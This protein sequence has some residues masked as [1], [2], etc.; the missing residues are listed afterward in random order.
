MRF[1]A[2]KNIIL[3]VGCCGVLCPLLSFACYLFCCCGSS[4]HV[5]RDPISLNT[6]IRN[7]SNAERDSYRP[8]S[9]S[10]QQK[11]GKGIIN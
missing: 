5:L 4:I 8:T 1:E 10:M 9:Q 7:R 2:D 11:I 6:L 3:F